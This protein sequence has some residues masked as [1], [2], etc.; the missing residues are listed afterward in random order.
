MTYLLNVISFV[1]TL[2]VLILAVFGALRL[3]GILAED[4]DVRQAKARTREA[5]RRIRDLGHEAQVQ[6]MRE[7]LRRAGR[8]SERDDR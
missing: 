7:A 5:E 4:E 3:V 8:P 6:I 1:G 2:L